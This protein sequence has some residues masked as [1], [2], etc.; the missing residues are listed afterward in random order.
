MPN[1]NNQAMDKWRKMVIAVI[2]ANFRKEKLY[3]ELSY[4]DRLEKI[5]STAIRIAQV[6][7]FNDI[8]QLK[9]QNIYNE[10]KNK[11]R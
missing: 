3:L 11:N 5:K 7:R 9:L 6:D 1:N 10:F 8:P 4:F 2:A